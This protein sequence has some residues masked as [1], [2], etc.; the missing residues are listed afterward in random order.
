MQRLIPAVIPESEENLRET[1]SRIV[2][3]TDEVQ[4]DIVDGKF[5]PFTSWPYVSGSLETSRVSEIFSEFKEELAIELDL[6]IEAPERVLQYFYADS[7]SRIVIH[8]ESTQSLEAVFSHS[9]EHGYLLGFSIRNDTPLQEL[10]RHID[11]I[12]FVQLMGIADIG[13][14]GQPFDE[15]VINRVRTLK[16]EVPDL[17]VSVDGSVNAETIAQLSEAGV[18]RFVSGSALLTA[19]DFASAFESLSSR[20]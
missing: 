17:E 13:S 10:L 3:V 18:D 8:L 14:Q 9:E 2:P 4:I 1:L 6:M 7:V 12:D 15:R 5:V 20:I 11:H 16:A 19:P